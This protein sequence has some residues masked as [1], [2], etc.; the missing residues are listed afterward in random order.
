[1]NR[2]A[3]LKINNAEYAAGQTVLS[4]MPTALFV[5][6]TQNCN[7]HC[8]M[9]GRASLHPVYDER[10]NMSGEIFNLVKKQLFP[11]ASLVDLRGLGESTILSD[12][13]S[14]LLETVDTGVKVRLVTNAL[15]IKPSL[16]KLLMENEAT[17]VVSVDAANPVL[18]KILGRGDFNRL[19]KSLDVAVEERNKAGN[20]GKIYFNTTVSSF[21]LTDIKEIVVLAQKYQ[22]DRVT[23]YPVIVPE[24][25]LLSLSKKRSEVQSCIAQAK[26][27][28]LELGVELRINMEFFEEDLIAEKRM[29]RCIRPWAVCYV[30]YSGNV[31]FCD[32]LMGR[33]F[34]GNITKTPFEDIWN[35]E[36]WQQLRKIHATSPVVLGC[37]YSPCNT[38]YKQRYI[39]FEDEINSD[40]IR[41]IVSTKYE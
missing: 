40:L 7:S 32:H 41:K 14:R 6:L 38:C 30:D 39:D 23:L 34:M 15:A 11:T 8:I 12:F 35:C 10:L 22:I 29:E 36:T 9:C 18:M 5:E 2:T 21:N 17:V 16:W 33:C 4:S 31:V 27:T 13:E 37:Q 28:A 25:H 19:L 26:A 3:N 1:M 24:K 20:R